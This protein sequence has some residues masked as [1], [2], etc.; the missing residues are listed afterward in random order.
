M[1]FKVS[2]PA[3]PL[4]ARIH[5]PTSKS[6]SNRVLII[7]AL[8]GFKR[9]IEDLSAAD[10]TKRL[11]EFFNGMP[12]T[13]NVGN[14]GTVMRFLCAFLAIQK[15][16][17]VLDGS[18]RMHKRTIRPLVDALRNL[19]ANIEYLGE[20]GFSPLRIQGNN[21]QGGVIKVNSSISSQFVSALILI[22]PYLKGGLKIELGEVAS[23][24]YLDMTKWTMAHFGVVVEE[25]NGILAVPEGK[26]VERT[27]RVPADHSSASYW[28]GM[29]ALSKNAEFFLEGLQLDDPQGDRA[30]FEI[31]KPHVEFE[32]KE[33]GLF[34]RNRSD[35]QIQQL[36]VDL[37][38]IPDLFPTLAFVCAGLGTE[39]HITGLQSLP[40]KE[41]DRLVAV[42]KELEN[43]GVGMK[44]NE[45]HS[46]HFYGEEPVKP[47]RPFRSYQDHRMV[48]SA[49]M[50][51]TIY[52]EVEIED[53]M[54]V[55][56]SYPTFWDEM[57]S[58][59]FKIEANS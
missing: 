40:H 35:G 28:A 10:D 5:I 38:S 39:A 12:T 7:Q 13:M 32:Q 46:V 17:F 24:S 27:F 49:A 31:L 30:I 25:Q 19:G 23:R 3:G 26:Y 37:S 43:I 20:D 57:E 34:I 54:V 53:P 45:D 47:K 50:M 4:T 44:I 55:E 59:G 22:G 18:D 33:D 48:M 2:R 58:A 9:T 21:L 16:A 41:T 1:T 11:E 6:I 51:I 52:S 29:A 15:G 36:E 56:K 14:A 42:Q 8:G